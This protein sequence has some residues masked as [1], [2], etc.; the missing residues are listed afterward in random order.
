[1]TTELTPPP[2]IPEGE[3][4]RPILL[5]RS[6]TDRVIG[7]VAGGLG[8]YLGIDPLIIRVAFVLLALTGG[9]GVLLYL[10]GWIAIP[11]ERV[12]DPVG[13]SPHGDSVTGRLI[14]GGTI[15]VIGS[16]LL[17]STIFP[18]FDQYLWPVAIVAI[19]AFIVMGGRR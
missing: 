19:G 10:I 6:T 7:G 13:K 16:I 1:M 9:S 3:T 12:G 14:V 2:V 4:G 15:M 18:A 5:R 11:E 8:R 17:V